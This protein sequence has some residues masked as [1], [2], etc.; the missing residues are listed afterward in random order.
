MATTRDRAL[1]AAVHLVGEQGIRALTHGRVDAAAGLPRGSTSNWFRTRD[2]LVS[3][4]LVWIAERERVALASAI[5]PVRTLD[6]LLDALCTVIEDATITFASRTRA[7]YALFF[8]T[9]ASPGIVPAIR[10][11]R[12]LFAKWTRDVLSGFGAADPDLAARTLL[13]L[14]AGIIVNRLT[15]D[16]DFPPRPS[17]E[18]ALRGALSGSAAPTDNQHPHR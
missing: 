4:V 6:E 2:A 1:E 16:P 8:E 10:E 13:G 15:V 9:T 5:R 7:R 11:Q 14:S 18:A 17:L 3:G 12:G